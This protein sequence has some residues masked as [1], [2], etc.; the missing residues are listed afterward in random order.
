MYQP[1]S[2]STS[3][4]ITL[5]KRTRYSAVVPRASKHWLTVQLAGR[6][7]TANDRKQVTFLERSPRLHLVVDNPC[8]RNTPFLL[9]IPYV[10]RKPVLLDKW[11]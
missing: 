4:S 2:S 9:N 6:V 1:C 11:S 8:G 5:C 3:G 7:R 10:C